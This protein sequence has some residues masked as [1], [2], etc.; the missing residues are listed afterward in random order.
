MA[1]AVYDAS[2]SPDPEV[3]AR[4][5]GVAREDVLLF[6]LEEDTTP[7]QHWPKFVLYFDHQERSSGHLL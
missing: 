6:G 5:L 1:L 7:G 3:Q 4:L 2:R